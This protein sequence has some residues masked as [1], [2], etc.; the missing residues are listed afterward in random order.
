MNH[1]F[2]NN[3]PFP[4]SFF[5]VSLRFRVILKPSSPPYSECSVCVSRERAQYLPREHKGSWMRMRAFGAENVSDLSRQ[6]LAGICSLFCPCTPD[7]L[8]ALAVSITPWPLP[9]E[10]GRPRR[11]EQQQQLPQLRRRRRRQRWLRPRARP[12]LPAA[13]RVRCWPLLVGRQSSSF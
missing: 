8:L 5:C 4:T 12:P 3:R 6:T 1:N 2:R 7:C 13:A 11:E 10:Q 9:R